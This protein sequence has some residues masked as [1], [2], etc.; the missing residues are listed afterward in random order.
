MS[1][2][3]GEGNKINSQFIIANSGNTY[4]T[5]YS[6]LGV[7][8]FYELTSKTERNN[9]PVDSLKLMN[10]D[11]FS[12]GRRR[13][14]MIV[15]TLDDDKYWQLL[16]QLKIGYRAGVSTFIA[17]SSDTR[18]SDS[19]WATLSNPEKLVLLDP[20]ITVFD[21]TTNRFY[22][23]SGDANTAW[24]DTPLQVYITGGTYNSGTTTLQLF[25]TSGNT[26]SITGIT[27]W[28]GTDVFV[29]GFTY[30]SNTFTIFNN[31]GSSYSATINQVTGLTVNG[32]LSATTISGGTLYGDG[33]NLTNIQNIYNTDGFLSSNRILDLSG[34]TLSYRTSS[35]FNQTFLN[36]LDSSNNVL[37]EIRASLT[38]PIDIE[39]PN[40]FI[41]KNA[42]ISTT[43]FVRTNLVV[44]NSSLTAMTNGIKNTVFGNYSFQKLV[45]GSFNTVI[46][47]TVAINFTGA[48]TGPNADDNIFIGNGVAFNQ[49]IG[50]Y[51][52]Y[53]GT[54]V[55]EFAVSGDSNTIVGKDAGRNGTGSGNV[56]LGY[57]AGLTEA[58]SNRLHISNSSNPLIYGEFD[59]RRVGVN[60]IS[61]TNTFQVSAATDPVRFEGL[62]L[63]SDT[64][65][66]T[67]D[68]NGVVRYRNLSEITGATTADTYTTGGTYT[69]A[70]GTLELR[71]NS[72]NTITITGFTTGSTGSLSGDYLPLSGGTVTGGTI[73]QSGLTANTIS[74][75]TISGG[76]LYG[77][78]SNLTNIDNIYTVDGSLQ[79][80]RVVDLSSYTLNFSSSTNPNTLVLNSGNIGI[81][82][83]T[84]I[85]PLHISNTGLTVSTSLISPLAGADILTISSQDTAPGINIISTSDSQGHRGVFKATRARGTLSSPT[86]PSNGDE[87]ISLL[88]AIYDGVTNWSTAGITME[89]DGVVTANTAPQ[90]IIFETGTGSSRTE[91]MRITSG[92]NVGIG[93]TNPTSFL[94]VNSPSIPSTNETIARFTVGDAPS[95]YLDLRN[96]TLVDGQFVGQMIGRQVS[97]NS[98][99][100]IYVD[101][102]IE[103]VEDVGGSPVT[104][105]RAFKISGSTLSS[106]SARTLFDFRNWTDSVMTIDA[107]GDVGI[108]TTTPT[109]KLHISGLT[110]PVRF[111]GLQS[112]NTDTRILTSDSNG[113]VK[114]RNFSD[115]TGG[116]GSLSGDYLPLSGGTVTGATIFQSGLTANTISA[117][118]YLG[119][120]SM[121]NYQ[122][123][124][125][126]YDDANTFTIFDNSGSTFPATINI[127]TGLTVNGVLSLPNTTGLTYGVVNFG[128]DPFIHNYGTGNTYVGRLAGS[129]SGTGSDNTGIGEF[130][131]N[132]LDNGDDNTGLGALALTDLTGGT[133]NTALGAGSLQN[134]VSGD[135]NTAVGV[136][137]NALLQSGSGNTSIGFESLF[138]NLTGSGNV[139]IGNKAGYNET[140]D[141]KLYIANNDITTLIYGEFDNERVGINTISPTNAF[142]VSASTDP[143]RFEGLQLSS[144]TRILTSDSNGV[145]RY[146]DLSEITGATSADTYVTAFTYSSNTF[147]I[148]DNS[149]NT[150]DA[151][152]DIVTG[153]TVNGDFNVTGDTTL[154]NLTANTISA[155]TYLN[156]PIKYYAEPSTPPTV[157]PIVTGTS[158]IAIGD[159]AEASGNYVLSFGQNAG[160]GSTYNDD[161]ISLGRN[162][163]VN[164]TSTI[165]PFSS[166]FISIGLDAGK[167][168]TGFGSIYVG[169]SAGSSSTNNQQN[170][171]IGS[172]AGFSTPNVDNSVFIGAFAGE[173]SSGS[174]LSSFI[175]FNAGTNSYQNTTDNFIGYLAGGYS[176]GNTLSNYIGNNAGAFSSGITASTFV[177]RYA[178]YGMNNGINNIIIGDLVGL[179]D[180]VSNSMNLGGV[181]FGINTNFGGIPPSTILKTPTVQ[182]KIG[183]GIVTP[184]NRLHVVDTSDPVRFDGMQ[185]I[186]SDTFLI[187]ANSNGVLRELGGN[188]ANRIPYFN[189]SSAITTNSGFT[190]TTPT[191]TATLNIPGNGQGATGSELSLN[192]GRA[193][194]TSTGIGGLNIYVG[195]GNTGG[196]LDT[197][198]NITFQNNGRTFATMFGDGS[199]TVT[200]SINTQFSSRV[201]IDT[202]STNMTRSFWGANGYALSVVGRTMTDTSTAGGSVGDLTYVSFGSPS[203][204]ATTGGSYTSFTTLYVAGAPTKTANMTGDTYALKVA[205][206][207]IFFGGLQLSSDTRILTSDSSGNIRYRNFSD[208]TGSTSTDTYT[209]A[210]TYNNNTFTIS[211]NTGQTFN[212]TINTVT[213]LTINGDLSVT[214]NTTLN[215]LTANTISASSLTINGVSITGDTYLTGATLSGGTLT[216]SQNYGSGVTVGDFLQYF[217]SATTPT[218]VVNSGDRWFNTDTGI[219]LVWIDDGNSTQWV[220]PFSVPGPTPDEGYYS[221]TGITTSQTITWDKTYWGISGSTN[222]DITLPTAVNKDGYYLVIKDESG[223]SGTN[224]IRLT[225]TS[226]TIDGNSY[227]DMNI[228]YMSLTLIARNGNWYII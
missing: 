178:G 10:G 168:T 167:D 175:G 70:T 125:F 227:V 145:V 65:I 170:V 115:F 21:S 20:T 134:L 152:I 28:P 129:F 103:S 113:V 133:F 53:L 136:A 135:D 41:G 206:G 98:Q 213:G 88:G 181:L 96:G 102:G 77:D 15:H 7:G 217:I 48:T 123:T 93:T 32:N 39:Y 81:G 47:D 141:N 161:S 57:R 164:S 194:L 80:N 143:V 45:R 33:S 172:N 18:V 149:G 195:N 188:V 25:D 205:S 148:S 216:L 42:G 186:T 166:Y 144:D 137:S 36:L 17:Y 63:S 127:T 99:P 3:L 101:G 177:G 26:I 185:T 204:S 108:G 208:F 112:G 61:L 60:T 207:G 130:V 128:S 183:I 34:K 182:G 11:G 2:N 191:G 54:N 100:A 9:I 95:A 140:G 120:P 179:P 220:Q 56:F 162:A 171:F 91:I 190:F 97:G 31:S 154:N 203:F 187:T 49:L 84:P 142:H 153:L 58:A 212:A 19:L 109:N 12:S 180:G 44:G 85:T 226:G 107:I 224:R 16:P 14:Q 110:D 106:L 169:S 199:S 200:D 158:S 5:N 76:T 163:G 147:T 43:P 221:T 75:T 22:F 35:G 126:T 197:S 46:G 192:G 90:R 13:L 117:T 40:L 111:E 176:S 92:G 72:G 30:S 193:R 1:I 59:N 160:S 165:L 202:T 114:Y 223:N 4:G 219:E 146:R 225:P 66:L 27:N 55:R 86:E 132:D 37:T 159:G 196:I 218:G 62:Q 174:S 74:A 23:G 78:G 150:F 151:T 71:D 73:F 79:S 198:K 228:N 214:G 51:N 131:L 38:V 24:F 64:R 156:F 119:L 89:V 138:N 83:T 222:V 209:T 105:F 8:G 52:V 122:I 184:L 87:T 29:T 189:S 173:F 157:S 6:Y 155:T 82:T 124:G 215:N 121:F 50:K 104:I 116:T 68:S 69:N 210:F 211:D 67:S 94:H 139:A 201:I 118:T